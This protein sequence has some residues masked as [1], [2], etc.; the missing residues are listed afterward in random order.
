VAAEP[1]G[2]GRV[3]IDRRHRERGHRK[4]GVRSFRP[5]C[6]DQA[7]RGA[8]VERAPAGTGRDSE[9]EARPCARFGRPG[10]AL[11]G[12]DIDP[13]AGG[14]QASVGESEESE[15]PGAMR[16]HRAPLPTRP[17]RGKGRDGN[18][19]RGQRDRQPGDQQHRN[20]EAATEAELGEPPLQVHGQMWEGRDKGP[21]RQQQVKVDKRAAD[22]RRPGHHQRH[23]ADEH[24]EVGEGQRAGEPALPG[25]QPSYPQL[26]PV[27]GDLDHLEGDQSARD[28]SEEGVRAVDPGQLDRQRQAESHQQIR[29]RGHPAGTDQDR[30]REAEPGDIQRPLRGD[31]GHPRRGALPRAPGNNRHAR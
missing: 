7:V 21:C 11:V 17:E 5:R 14:Q 1:K 22:G 18:R 8:E 27:G 15:H 6:G 30:Q 2:P 16:P 23:A 31:A 26:D 13:G 24:A 10:P 28:Q 20:V 19:E 3:W 12:A 25:R 4:G 9:D 29:G